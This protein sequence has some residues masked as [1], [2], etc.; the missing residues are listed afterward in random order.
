VEAA[1]GAGEA[2]DVGTVVHAKQVCHRCTG[3]T[4]DY[5]ALRYSWKQQIEAGEASDVG[6]VV[7]AKQVCHTDA[8]V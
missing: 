6:T 7:Y 4:A 8:L 5:A 1:A 2:S 3:A